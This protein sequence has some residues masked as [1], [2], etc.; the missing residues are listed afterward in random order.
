MA[1]AQDIELPSGVALHDYAAIELRRPIFVG[2]AT[3]LDDPQ[4]LDVH[5]WL[6]RSDADDDA[7]SAWEDSDETV[8]LSALESTEYVI[9]RPSSDGEAHEDRHYT[10]HLAYT[11]PLY[12]GQVEQTMEITLLGG[13][14]DAVFGTSNVDTVTTGLIHQ[15]VTDQNGVSIDIY[16]GAK[17][18]SLPFGQEAIPTFYQ[19]A[20]F[21]HD[22]LNVPTDLSVTTIGSF[23][24]GWDA[25]N[26][27]EYV[28]SRYDQDSVVEDLVTNDNAFLRTLRR[29]YAGRGDVN[30]A[31]DLNPKAGNWTLGYVDRLMPLTLGPQSNPWATPIDGMLLL[32]RDGT[33][34][35]Y[36]TTP[37]EGEE[38]G[39]E[40][41]VENYWRQANDGLYQ[42]DP[43]GTTAQGLTIGAEGFDTVTWRKEGL[44]EN[45]MYQVFMPFGMR[46]DG[47][48]LTQGAKILSPLTVDEAI[49]L[50]NGLSLDNQAWTESGE[51]SLGFFRP[52]ADGV[53]EFQAFAGGEDSATFERIGSLDFVD[54]WTFTTPDGSFATLEAV[55]ADEEEEGEGEGGEGGEGEPEELIHGTVEDD[56]IQFVLTTNRGHRYEFDA[57]GYLKREVTL[58]GNQTAYSYETSP[59]LD[60][61]ARL[62]SITL[63]GGRTIELEYA[64]EYPYSRQLAKI[65]DPEGFVTRFENGEVVTENPSVGELEEGETAPSFAMRVKIG[66]LPVH[67]GPTV[68]A[69]EIQD[70]QV[71][72]FV[73]DVGFAFDDQYRQKPTGEIGNRAEEHEEG[74]AREARAT[75]TTAYFT[76]EELD[77]EGH[78]WT[79][80][81]DRFGLVTAKAAPKATL[82]DPDSEEDV[83]LWQR[84]ANSGLVEK[85]KAPAG[86]GYVGGVGDIEP[87]DIDDPSEGS[88]DVQT[89]HDLDVISYEYFENGYLKKITYDDKNTE[90][91]DDDI[92]EKWE[93]NSVGVM[94]KY[95]DQ[96]G[97][98]TNY[99]PDD[100]GHIETATSP[101]GQ[102]VTY[103]Y[104]DA[105]LSISDAPGGQIEFVI[106]TMNRVTFYDYYD[107]G[108]EK[109]LLERK[110]TAL[111]SDDQVAE[112][113][114]YDEYLHLK[115]YTDI[116]GSITTYLVDKLGRK[117]EATAGRSRLPEEEGEEGEGEGGEGEAPAEP[118]L[119]EGVTTSYT[120]DTVGN[121]RSVTTPGAEDSGRKR[122]TNYGYDS[123]NQLTDIFAPPVTTLDGEERPHTKYVYRADGQVWVEYAP[124]NHSIVNIYDE[125]GELFLQIE[126]PTLDGSVVQNI[127]D[128]PD[129]LPY[130]ST[131][132]DPFLTR[133]TYD[134]AGNLAQTQNSKGAYTLTT[135][136]RF[137]R[138]QEETVYA[139]DT[140]KLTTTYEYFDDG[141]IHFVRT[142]NPTGDGLATTEYAYDAAGRLETVTQPLNHTVRY[143]Y[144][145]DDSLQTQTTKAS[146]NVLSHV[147]YVYDDLGRTKET[148]QIVDGLS[149]LV[150]TSVDY[151]LVDDVRTE[152]YTDGRGQV[153]TLTYDT[154]GRVTKIERPDPDGENGLAAPIVLRD[155]FDDSSLKSETLTY[156]GADENDKRETTYTYDGAGLV[157][158]VKAQGLTTTYWHD[159]LGNVSKTKANDNSYVTQTYNDRGWLA[160]TAQYT[161]TGSVVTKTAYSYDPR[162]LLAQ[163]DVDMKYDLGTPTTTSTRTG[164]DALGRV[165]ANYNFSA[166]GRTNVFRHQYFMTTGLLDETRSYASAQLD[167]LQSKTL[168]DYDDLGRNIR[169]II[170]YQ[171]EPG[172]EPGTQFALP[173][174]VIKTDY[175]DENHQRRVVDP[176]KTST[177]YTFDNLGRTIREV[178]ETV[179]DSLNVIAPAT[180]AREWTYD[181][182]GNVET[183]KDRRNI[184]VTYA[185]DHLDRLTGETSG[186]TALATFGFNN[187]G[188]MVLAENP[189]SKYDFYFDELGRNEET[190]FSTDLA[191][192]GTQPLATYKMGFDALNRRNNLLVTAASDNGFVSDLAF[193]YDSLNRLTEL[194]ERSS[195][196]SSSS[197]GWVHAAAL[198]VV[199]SY[200][201]LTQSGIDRK[202][203]FNG[204]APRTVLKTT[205]D[206]NVGSELKLFTQSVDALG[207]E[208]TVGYFDYIFNKLGQVEKLTQFPSIAEATTKHFQ[209]YNDG[210]LKLG[211]QEH[212]LDDHGSRFGAETVNNQLMSLDLES[213]AGFPYSIEYAY[214]G[215]GNRIEARYVIQQNFIDDY[216]AAFVL[217]AENTIYWDFG[218]VDF[219]AHWDPKLRIP[220]GQVVAAA[221]IVSPKY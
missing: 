148:K 188:D 96:V 165:T 132:K 126:S 196:S 6:E 70:V 68:A 189:D 17:S 198:D 219:P 9:L 124:T 76:D 147:E 179:D 55:A 212:K 67:T 149:P 155:Y 127:E 202:Q 85:Y 74:E 40:F 15:T 194:H 79:Y 2:A 84:K 5:W 99:T 31:A 181:E 182:N 175:D 207:A 114:K 16:S 21:T 158:T 193:K 27:S 82:N 42:L 142:P 56:H 203:S 83:W 44:D 120:Y 195:K 141:Q 41:E 169:S 177:L 25:E 98:V 104:T 137:Q 129:E 162:G 119:T 92:T 160:E 20:P 50:S 100:Y 153:T 173:D 72:S 60:G 43:W 191:Y 45:R 168:Y 62:S 122:V 80:Q 151:E 121:L 205:I 88:F 78:V 214:D 204:A 52:N 210:Q 47:L 174:K 143:A 89:D 144:Y 170:T 145:A 217:G 190:R 26:A 65:T 39:P 103:L 115:E 30:E 150:T 14:P 95:T 101:L 64:G 118:E 97:R 57:Q 134:Q 199:Y 201:G 130:Y 24:G 1:A 208:T 215:E 109:G 86:R 163:T 7:S 93:Y 63:Q 218:V 172:I 152:A 184:T 28:T 138:V 90:T 200:N 54:S 46:T 161:S 10:L 171:P 180:V 11:N 19:Y 220:R 105:P 36:Q 166:A 206:N 18:W 209:Y 81:F 211:A 91:L 33:S 213:Q 140:A 128:D 216:N 71:T 221:S 34:A 94:T 108:P 136:D 164:Y 167:S 106:D 131:R 87:S 13:D 69:P 187:F 37:G 66:G 59:A 110:T 51:A 116:Y 146:N 156:A 113:F 135:F 102:T 197:G 77:D 4:S 53:I 111:G 35:W 3:E 23:F 159:L 12:G 112:E 154:L 133:F 49:L 38:V 117:L 73:F 125:R 157:R 186:G 185:Y 183:Y 176:G 32:R 192:N 48:W 29:G 61:G 75:V 139:D 178:E 58:D 8:T 123:R 22:L 107:S